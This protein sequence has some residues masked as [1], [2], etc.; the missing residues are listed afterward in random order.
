MKIIFVF[1]K[2]HTITFTASVLTI[3]NLSKQC[4]NAYE[5]GEMIQELI[6]DGLIFY[7]NLNNVLYWYVQNV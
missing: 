4:Y 5:S 2:E 3:E 7:I 1:N 6:D